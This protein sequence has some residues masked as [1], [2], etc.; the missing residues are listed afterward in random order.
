MW[1]IIYF[2][3]T[4][5]MLIM[6]WNEV[7]LEFMKLLILVEGCCRMKWL[8][9]MNGGIFLC[10]L[11]VIFNITR[12]P[13]EREGSSLLSQG[14]LFSNLIFKLDLIDLPL[15]GGACTWSNGKIW[16]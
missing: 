10:V 16:S 1:G 12:Y 7:L 2:L 9:S 6:E 14:S 4:L 8:V 3:V 11:D 5:K 13:I 15:V